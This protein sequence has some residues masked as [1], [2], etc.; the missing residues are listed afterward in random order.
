M[1]TVTDIAILS[2][3]VRIGRNIQSAINM[4]HPVTNASSYLDANFVN[5]YA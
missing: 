1:R 5:L 4:N 3:L 2:V